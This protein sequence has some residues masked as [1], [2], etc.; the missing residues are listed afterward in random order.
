MRTFWRISNY[1]DLTG[2]GAKLASARWHTKG[3][4]IVYLADSPAGA[5]LER[6]VQLFDTE[7]QLPRAY[8]LLKI[9]TS[10]EIACKDLLPLAEV[11][12]KDRLDLTREIG[13]VWL[14]SRETALARVPSAI[15][16]CTWNVLLNPEHP[17]AKKVEI[18]QVI[19][20]RFDNRLLRSGAR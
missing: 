19:K 7:G 6:L 3:R 14:A 9:E 1:S 13:E 18:A 17:D 11:D 16:P 10:E 12:W 2:E 8:D 20:E 4:L 5:M 15:M